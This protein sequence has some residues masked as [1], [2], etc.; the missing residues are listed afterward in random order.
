MSL[1][2]VVEWFD[3]WTHLVCGTASCGGGVALSAGRCEIVHVH[4]GAGVDVHLT[5]WAIG[6]FAQELRQVAGVRVPENCAWV[7]VG[8][9]CQADSDVLMT[10]V[11]LALHAHAADGASR[12]PAPCTVRRVYGGAVR[13]RWR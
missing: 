10:L 7:T 4:E 11:S 12:A 5:R 8:V 3:E 6:R 1:D 9:E 13:R 2:S